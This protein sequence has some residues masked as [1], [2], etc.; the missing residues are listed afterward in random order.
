MPTVYPQN[1]VPEVWSPGGYTEHGFTTW[2]LTS[3]LDTHTNS[4]WA[5]CFVKA[6][7]NGYIAVA[8]NFTAADFRVIS[9][10]NKQTQFPNI[11]LVSATDL[12]V[13]ANVFE[14]EVEALGGLTFK[15]TEDDLGTPISDDATNGWPGKPYVLA[16]VTDPSDTNNY[17]PTRA[18]Q[19]KVLLDSS[20]ITATPT[21]TS[22]QI[23]G[24]APLLGNTYSATASASPR[25]FLCLPYLPGHS[26]SQ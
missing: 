3:G 6:S 22:F 4:I 1:N 19:G 26:Q 25:V 16:L 21:A 18:P 13:D 8:S 24:V 15:V 11:Q 20:T 17:A 5:G 7:T 9:I 10:R 2:V 14:L 12:N 23:I